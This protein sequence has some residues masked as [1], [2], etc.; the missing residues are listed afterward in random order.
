MI[1]DTISLCEFIQHSWTVF[2]ETNHRLYGANGIIKI[3]SHYSYLE[4][5]HKRVIIMQTKYTYQHVTCDC[6]TEK[7]FYIKGT[8]FPRY[9]FLSVSH[10]WP[11]VTVI[12]MLCRVTSLTD[13]RIISIP[14]AYTLI[15]AILKF[16]V[17][18][19]MR[20]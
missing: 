11:F 1:L 2:D 10:I 17:N 15:F 7:Y 19:E 20:Y 8:T 14:N 13:T 18:L 3:P 6:K 5:R 9:F 16:G 4:V 12:L